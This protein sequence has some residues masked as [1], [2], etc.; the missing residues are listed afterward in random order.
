MSGHDIVVI[1]G[2]AGGLKALIQIC[3]GLPAGFPASVFVVLHRRRGTPSSLP[4]LLDGAGPL[5]A[6]EAVDAAAVSRGV[7]TV[8]PPDHHLLLRPGHMLLRRGPYENRTRPAIDPLF[9]SAAIAYRARVMGVVLSGTLDDGSAGLIAVNACG[10]I[11]IVQ[12]PEDADW[13]EMPKNALRQD[14]VDHCVA[15]AEMPELLCRL[16]REPPGPMPP[17]PHSLILENRIAMQ[18]MV[19]PDEPTVGRPSRITCPQCGGVLNAIPE[20]AAPCF[21]CQTGHAFSTEALLSAQDDEIER[22]LDTAL[23]MHCERVVLFRR[24]QEKAKRDGL[25][26]TATH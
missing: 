14:H 1:G 4:K 16:V 9:R 23:R 26:L 19:T 8:A 10:G 24:M 11:C 25:P 22:A 6:Q 17:I 21:R 3:A 18:E 20:Q 7:I 12:Q 2:S 13:P 5:R 15:A